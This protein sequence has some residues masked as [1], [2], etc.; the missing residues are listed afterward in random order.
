M[1]ESWARNDDMRENKYVSKS[2]DQIEKN[3]L[4]A[5]FYDPRVYSFKPDVNSE[6]GIVTLTGVVS[7][8]KAREAA[9]QV[10]KNTV[11]V[12]SVRNYLKVRPV[13]VPSN[14]ELETRIDNSW[15][16]DP[17]VDADEVSAS[18]FNGV[19]TLSG[20][21][22]TYFEKH[23]AEDA[24]L[25]TKGVIAVDNNIVVRN[26]YQAYHW[27]YTGW[28]NLYPPYYYTYEA[29][30]DNKTD[31]EIMKD[32]EEQIWWS[33]YVNLDD[34]D[35]SVDDHIAT[36]TGVVDTRREK[37]FAEINALEGGAEDVINKLEV[38]FAPE[39]K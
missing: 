39:E 12:F 9:E 27:G 23:Q 35:I 2:D 18:V 29:D 6:N 19:A 32:I 33:P 36:L 17:V 22:N 5:Y 13:E 34:V 20:T 30:E 38:E 25:R 1:V 16:R 24:V 28:N 7:N 11:G 15:R 26:D 3:I 21:V 14:Q 10:A 37:L 4:D 31:W 8:L